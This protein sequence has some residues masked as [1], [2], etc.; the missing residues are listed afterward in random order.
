[1]SWVPFHRPSIGEDEIAAVTAVM[2]SGW[3]TSGEQCKK[4]EEEFAAFVRAKHAVAVNSCTA[5]L[6]LAL[7]AAGVQRG[8]L[9]LVPTWTFAATAEVVIHLGATPVLVDADPR[10]LHLD[11]AHAA[12]L[13]DA[14]SLGRA[15]PGVVFP[16]PPRAVMPVHFAGEMCDVDGIDVL[17][18]QYH[19]QVIEDAAHAL[20]S[21][22][23]SAD[24][25]WRTVGTTAAQTCFSFYANKTITTGE[26]GMLV[27][28]D[29]RLAEQAR[30]LALHGLSRDAW[31]RFGKG[32]SWDYQILAAGY[33]YNLTDMAAAL[34]RVQLKR[35]YELATAR[36]KVARRYNQLLEDVEEIQLPQEASDRRSAWHLYVI[37]L[38]LDRLNIG[39]DA[40]IEELT[41]A[42]IGASVHWRPLHLHRYYEETY[43]LDPEDFPV[44]T[45]E[46]QRCISL[47]IFP[48]QTEE[49]I[50]HVCRTVRAIAARHARTP[51]RSVYG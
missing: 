41:Q 33:K 31:S 1:M 28:N 11:V 4:F 22:A 23:R 20:P 15:V 47:P 8:D 26:G 17:A 7:A 37:R 49:E 38:H 32:G 39:R 5:A 13:C 44:A 25:H 27:T 9:V 29:D 34:G 24:G 46:W 3:L 16:A 48:G 18:S 40:F 12:R 21:F 51:V 35:A 19:L 36:T 6:H 45:A 50:D 42:G 30:R 10:A 43:A 2:R 14:L